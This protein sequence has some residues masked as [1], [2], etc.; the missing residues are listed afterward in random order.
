MT[1]LAPATRGRAATIVVLGVP[2]VL[3]SVAVAVTL[4]P[5]DLSVPD[6]A[7][8]VGARL[9]LGE[10][11][12]SRIGQGIVWELRLPRA[13]LAGICGAGLAVCGAVLQSLLRNPLADPFL[14]GI[15]AGASTGAVT[16]VVLGAGAGVIGLTAGAFAGAVLAFTLVVVL[17]S[18]AGGGTSRV[19]L[20]GVAG[21]QLFSALTSYIVI[22]SADAEQTRGVLFWLL[23]SLSG[24]RWSDVALAG[25]V[26]AG[27]LLLCLSRAAALDAF[28][29]GRDAAASLGVDVRRLRAVLLG[30]TALLAA[31]LVAAAGAIG[32]VGLVLPH[33]AR[34]LVGPGHRAL[35]PVTAV[36]GAILLIW[37]D[38]LATTVAAPLEV[39]V[40]VVTALVGVPAFAA[41]MIRRGRV[42]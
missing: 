11:A 8:V 3:L 10:T 28:A 17:A 25:A 36:L 1:A 32:F 13:L 27:C 37:V 40:G 26:C 19:I 12:V 4:G 14:L 16:V 29:F 2:A 34:L 33:A 9:G 20:A 42:P 22:T 24:A 23:G 7:G 30:I 6:V 39:P 5:A 41:L 31:T 18:V 35:L 38:V 15:S 21:T